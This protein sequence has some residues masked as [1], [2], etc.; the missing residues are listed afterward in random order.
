MWSNPLAGGYFDF[1]K[2]AFLKKHEIERSGS[3]V[4]GAPDVSDS[5][6]QKVLV[7]PQWYRKAVESLWHPGGVLQNALGRFMSRG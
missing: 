6:V 2:F 7:F 5:S 4:R 3:G 1:S